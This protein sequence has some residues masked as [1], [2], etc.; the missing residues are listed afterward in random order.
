MT[1][2]IKYNIPETESY[3]IICGGQTKEID[4]L[5]KEVLFDIE[6]P[7]SY[8]ITVKQLEEK[9]LPRAFYIPFFILTAPVIGIFNALFLNNETNWEEDIRAW[10]LNSYFDID[11]T[12]DTEITLTAVNSKYISHHFT[13]PLLTVKPENS[14]NYE[15]IPNRPDFS[16]RFWKFTRK[17]ISVFSLAF[18]LFGFMLIKFIESSNTGGTIFAAAVLAILTPAVIYTALWNRKKMK[19]LIEEFEKTLN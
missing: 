14:V 4:S 18:V 19:R 10:R 9:L 15:N 8:R 13:E 16:R 17:L 2:T 7:G 1:L 5:S 12:G 6:K 3:E 11:I